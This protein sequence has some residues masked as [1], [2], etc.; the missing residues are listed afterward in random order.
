LPF[1][2]DSANRDPFVELRAIAAKNVTACHRE[3]VGI[4]LADSF[5]SD[6][7]Y[8]TGALELNNEEDMLYRKFTLDPDASRCRVVA[9]VESSR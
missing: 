9:S 5:E 6:W 3:D 8:G 2:L 1:V 7:I 4:G